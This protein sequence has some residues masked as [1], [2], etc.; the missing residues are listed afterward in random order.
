MSG[1]GTD[2]TLTAT[3]GL[4][5]PIANMAVGLWGDLLNTNADAIDA[6]IHFA[7]GG[8]PFLPLAG[9]SVFGNTIFSGSL[10]YTATNGTIAR[11]AQDRAA[12]V[13]N[14]LDFGADPT[15]VADSTAAI[16]AA[17][18]SV[19][20]G[21]V[22]SVQLPAGTYRVTNALNLGTATQGQCLFGDGIAA[23]TITVG[24]D[25]NTAALG[26]IILTPLPWPAGI[27]L[28]HCVRD[29]RIVFQQPNDFVTTTT[30]VSNAGA[31]TV[32]VAS[33][34][35][36]AVGQTVY[37]ETAPTTLKNVLPGQSNSLTSTT[38]ASIAGNVITLSPPVVSTIASGH[39]LTF[40]TTRAQFRTLAANA[41]APLVAGAP[42]I[43]YPWAIYSPTGSGGY[44]P[45]NT[46]ID[47]VQIGQ[48]WDG[49]HIRGSTIYIGRLE[50]A[51]FDIGLDIGQ[52]FNFS[53]LDY[54]QFYP[55]FGA[56]N[57]AGN[58][59]L[60]SV[61][62]DGQ[63]IAA[64][65][66]AG[67]TINTLQTF[68]GIVNYTNAGPSSSIAHLQLDG[69]NSNFNVT[70]TF[71]A[72][73]IANCYSTKGSWTHG[74]PIAINAAGTTVQ[75]GNLN[76]TDAQGSNSA[77]TVAAGTLTIQNALL[78]NGLQGASPYV[79]VSGGTFILTN[80]QLIGQPQPGVPYI[81][82]T[83]GS[84]RLRHV[85]FD[86]NSAGAGAAGVAVTDVATND[87]R[88]IHWNGW[89]MGGLPAVPLGTYEPADSAI[90][91]GSYKIGSNTY[92]AE[93]DL[94]IASAAGQTRSVLFQSAGNNRWAL[95]TA[96]T[97]E[98]GGSTGSDFRLDRYLDSGFADSPIAIT[99]AT[100]A[101]Q[102]GS[103]GTWSAN[104]TTAV[105]LT[106]LAPS[107]AHATVQEWLTLTD[108]AGNVRYIPCF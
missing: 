77:I 23:T 26:V 11:A 76:I 42:G 38:V 1:A 37:N 40:G 66:G 16:N 45:H 75:I 41:G 106:A 50:V 81:S 34:T 86:T 88:D 65:L 97:A 43:R 102:L 84:I 56:S 49:V 6:A 64:N 105:S 51:A 93:V 71:G 83:G 61:S 63:A 3:L 90:I 30:A 78:W 104:G 68:S 57:P 4:Y 89:V 17:L 59:A 87:I 95:R 48:A 108:A 39:N 99:R 96:L 85:A 15:G 25:F 103:S 10:L 53:T 79:L 55:G 7:S 22:R 67:L 33:A 80:T 70:A 91:D 24:P 101:M 107:G 58:E 47:N 2:Y 35:G 20:F 46:Y 12:D 100:G 18:A 9:G 73:G 44:L 5:K 8:G 98:S 32:T 27:S 14:V 54:Y 74:T 92:G 19:R 69:D 82:Q 29:L 21:A 60:T 94:K 62:Y 72:I 13:A 31:T 36:I 28:G 52:N